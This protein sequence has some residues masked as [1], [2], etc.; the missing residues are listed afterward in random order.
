MRP[1]AKH[2]K[3]EFGGHIFSR[4]LP[5][6]AGIL[7]RKACLARLFVVCRK[8]QEQCLR[9]H[10]SVLS[11]FPRAPCGNSSQNRRNGPRNQPNAE[12]TAVEHPVSARVSPQ[13]LACHKSLVLHHRP[14]IKQ[15]GHCSNSDGQRHPLLFAKRRCTYSGTNQT[16]CQNFWHG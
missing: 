11:R 8:F 9:I 16:Q 13:R 2:K 4:L 10:K 5:A 12:D 15:R 1:T 6:S 7:V 3:R 14:D